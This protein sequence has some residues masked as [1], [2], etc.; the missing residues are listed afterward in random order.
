EAPGYS[1]SS[2]RDLSRYWCS[3][4]KSSIRFARL[5]RQ[6][7]G[8]L[9]IFLFCCCP[10]SFAARTQPLGASDLS[11][12]RFDQH[13]QDRIS[14]DLPI[15][16]ESGGSVILQSYFHGKPVVLTLGY[17]GCPML[18]GMVLNGMVE[19]FQDLKA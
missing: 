15:T 6:S 12:I 18:C 7:V 10:N 17:Y 11:R 14:L 13:L 2:L 4:A 5:R 3:V 8:S 9:L 1:Q 16:D 19:A